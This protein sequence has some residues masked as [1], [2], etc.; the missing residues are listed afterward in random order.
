MVKMSPSP[1]HHLAPSASPYGLGFGAMFDKANNGGGVF[2]FQNG[3]PVNTRTLAAPQG[4]PQIYTAVYSGVTV[5]EMEVR[6]VLCM[7]R[8]E[9]GWLNATQIL[10]VAGIDKGKRTKVLEKEVLPGE[11]EKVQ[12]GFGKYQG[13]WISYARGREFCQQYGVEELLKP[14]LDHD[15]TANGAARRQQ[16]TPT[17]EQAMAANRKR[18]Y[19]GQSDSNQTSSM[20]NSPFHGGLSSTSSMALAAVNKAAR[21]PSSQPPFVSSAHRPP[22]RDANTADL[23]QNSSMAEP[24]RKRK[25]QSSTDSWPTAPTLDP[26]LSAAPLPSHG[27]GPEGTN[28]SAALPPIATSMTEQQNDKIDLIMEL[29]TPTSS[30]D[31]S[32]REA[33]MKLT[34]EDLMLPLDPSANNALHWAAMTARAPLMRML[35]QKGADTWRGNAAGLTPLMSAV[36]TANCYTSATFPEFLEMLGPLI[37][38]RDASGR[39]VLH[40]IAVSA[41]IKGR[42]PICK[43]YLETLLEYLVRI[44]T[45][46]SERDSAKPGT[47]SLVRFL[48][49]VVNARD[50]AGNTALHMAARL[51]VRSIIQQLL[52]IHAD[53]NLPNYK[54]FAPKDFGIDC[55]TTNESKQSTVPEIDVTAE[56]RPSQVDVLMEE[57]QSS[58]TGTLAQQLAAHRDLLR[59]RNEQIDGINEQIRTLS[60]TQQAA[61]EAVQQLKERQQQREE[62]LAK[63]ESYE[64]A[65]AKLRKK[66]SSRSPQGE[67]LWRKIS[68]DGSTAER[69]AYHTALCAINEK[70]KTELEQLRNRSRPTENMY[71]RV[72]SICTD[73]PEDRVDEAL[74]S[75]LAAVESERNGLLEGDQVSRVR[76]FLQR[77]GKGEKAK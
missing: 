48:S 9:D 4:E 10:K 5:Y 43:Y 36:L 24:S 27:D 32:L 21:L 58:I 8:C 19:Q 42:A 26:A 77:V 69:E 22:E 2:A 18:Y 12:G 63:K 57:I 51:G 47:P 45:P 73:V 3:S 40:H 60:T 46:S 49:H 11:H 1:S 56:P 17:K 14:L 16:D 35:I 75:L 33:L 68:Q 34:A 41:G 31:Y 67:L 28:E 6:G 50:K 52:E 25:R 72:V 64:R 62:R 70:L 71:R 53:P 39:T 37:E 13:T 65:I 7:R 15:V 76:E 30:S 66:L 59:Q 74:P 61:R 29:F 38:A 23:Y 55:G 20:M 44:G 54:G